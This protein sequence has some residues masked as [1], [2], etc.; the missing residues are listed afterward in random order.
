MRFLK[1]IRSHYDAAK[2]PKN[3]KKSTHHWKLNSWRRC[4]PNE[5]QQ[6]FR[7]E[8]SGLTWSLESSRTHSRAMK[9]CAWQRCSPIMI[10]QCKV[11]KDMLKQ[12]WNVSLDFS[13]IPT[14]IYWD[15]SVLFG[16]THHLYPACMFLKWTKCPWLP[17][18]I[19]CTE[20]E[21]KLFEIMMGL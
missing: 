21:R 6:L 12:W 7:F 4:L 1:K 13:T 11:F 15:Y 5:R 17:T 18:N 16:F 19:L 14:I 20:S 2:F 8:E 3:K 10:A 9:M